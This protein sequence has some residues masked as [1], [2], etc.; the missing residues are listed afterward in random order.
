MITIVD[1]QIGNVKS[2]YN[3][4]TY[5]G[6]TSTITCDKVEIETAEKII[7][8]GVGSFDIGMETIQPL[9]EVLTEKVFFQK[10]PCLGICL[11][12]Q[13][14]CQGSDEG[15]HKGLGWFDIHVKKLKSRRV[16]HLGWAYLNTCNEWANSLGEYSK[17]Y[18]AHSYYLPPSE[19]TVATTEYEGENFSAIIQ[20]DNILGVQFHPEKSHEYGM[21]LLSFFSRM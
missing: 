15:V 19:E 3:M 14:M 6:V 2:I 8:P 5:L 18:F 16:P 11:G 17:F 1:T 7:L 21:N 10:V 13:L 12:M 4:L 20:R 9:K